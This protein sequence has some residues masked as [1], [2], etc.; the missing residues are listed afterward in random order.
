M[1]ADSGLMTGTSGFSEHS[2]SFN[3][4]GISVSD[5]E[6][7]AVQSSTTS[8]PV[9]G[10]TETTGLMTGNKPSNGPKNTETCQNVL[11]DL[12]SILKSTEKIEQ[13]QP[14]VTEFRES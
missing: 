4:E 3:T 1:T 12:V 6:D 14:K 5:A 7:L 11:T 2:S 9:A 13:V 10:G 8:P